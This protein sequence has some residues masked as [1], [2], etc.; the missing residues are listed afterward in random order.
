MKQIF[1][2]TGISIENL[3]TKIYFEVVGY[4]FEAIMVMKS[5]QVPLSL[6]TY[7]YVNFQNDIISC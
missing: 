7:S 1:C 2:E 5:V 6:H 3:I 4:N